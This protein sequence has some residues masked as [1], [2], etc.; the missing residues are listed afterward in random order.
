MNSTTA[1]D[2]VADATRRAL[3]ELDELP[4]DAELDAVIVLLEAHTPEPEPNDPDASVTHVIWK[5]SPRISHPWLCGLLATAE[6]LARTGYQ[7]D[8]E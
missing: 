2:A 6:H 8:T 1:A 4:P 3:D 7:D 5:V